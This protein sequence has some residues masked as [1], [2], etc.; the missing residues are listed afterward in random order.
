MVVVVASRCVLFVR[1][2]N[3]QSQRFVFASEDGAD[4]TPITRSYDLVAIMMC[5]VRSTASTRDVLEKKKVALCTN[6]FYAPEGERTSQVDECHLQIQ[7]AMRCEAKEADTNVKIEKR[8]EIPAKKK[9]CFSQNLFAVFSLFHSS[10]HIVYNFIK[11][12]D[13]I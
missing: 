3:L 10:F 13:A 12:Y 4:E 11:I 7:R 1:F 5:L 8:F 6:L 9:R 2:V